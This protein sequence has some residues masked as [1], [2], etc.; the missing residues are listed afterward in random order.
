M[1]N[2]FRSLCAGVIVIGLALASPAG[3]L[4]CRRSGSPPGD[5]PEGPSSRVLWVWPPSDLEPGQSNRYSSYGLI[6]YFR[7]T[8]VPA[9]GSLEIT[10]EPVCQNR[11]VYSG[12]IVA[13]ILE[14]DMPSPSRKVTVTDA[15][16]GSKL[17]E[18]S[19]PA[20]TPLPAAS[21]L[22]V[23][24]SEGRTM[25]YP[26]GGYYS[27]AGPTS[28]PLGDGGTAYVAF[29]EVMA[30]VWL[31]GSV[32]EQSLRAALSPAPPATVTGYRPD[33]EGGTLIQVRWPELPAVEGSPFPDPAA[34]VASGKAPA[35]YALEMTLT[36][37]AAKLPASSGAAVA[38]G[39]D[40]RFEVRAVRKPAPDFAV[41]CREPLRGSLG[42]ANPVGNTIFPYPGYRN[43]WWLTPEP[44]TFCIRFTKPMDR[45]S[46]ERALIAESISTAATTVTFNWLTDRAVDVVLAPRLGADGEPT[47][48]LMTRLAAE[49]AVDT[50]GLPIWFVDSLWL[51]WS[52]PMELALVPAAGPD[53]ARTPVLAARHVPT[54]A[55]I[56]DVYDVPGGMEGEDR[57]AS[58]GAEGVSAGCFY[59]AL[60]PAREPED[61]LAP[62]VVWIGESGIT[63]QWWDSSSV[64]ES[65]RSAE[66]L[67]NR[68]VFIDRYSSWEVTD[69]SKTRESGE[70]LKVSLDSETYRWLGLW[71][72]PDGQRVAAFRSRRDAP[73]QSEG[74]LAVDLVIYDLEGR[75]TLVVPDATRL[76]NPYDFYL[77][78]IPTAWL[79]DGSGL[80]FVDRI[81]STVAGAPDGW[82]GTTR[83]ARLDL[84]AGSQAR[85]T[86]LPNSGGASRG[87]GGRLRVFEAGTGRQGVAGDGALYAAGFV[88]APDGG[89]DEFRVESL[90][91]GE[92]L[93][94]AR[95]GEK[96]LPESVEACLPS[97]D[98]RFLAVSG[99]GRTVVLDVAALVAAGGQGTAASTPP[100]VS[101]YDGTVV[102]WTDD[103]Q[104]VY[105]WR[106]GE[107][108]WGE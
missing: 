15:A 87:Q 58:G 2:F 46:V 85:P 22:R 47:T 40:G 24:I 16:S 38:A 77:D 13:V 53:G 86:P 83:L 36:I 62:S 79:P 28:P 76:E 92:V 44:H 37:D 59:L 11:V 73:D 17:A 88:H 31:P 54:G 4:G 34:A 94:A 106:P 52:E 68:Q 21:G 95:P 5:K 55:R 14:G 45:P 99:S 61:G 57:S 74:S 107:W 7:F 91:T 108:T 20:P 98:G 75:E 27:S 18:A 102:A 42:P 1:T 69:I 23:E 30:S 84:T 63:L 26:G 25:P 96:S 8:D 39:P 100:I 49:G 29:G 82:Y 9:E 3:G 103:S 10:V 67:G 60:E 65:C 12:N 89:P 90:E 56:V 66:F 72:S 19:L 80:V 51:R 6:A 33:W 97:P 78:R 41:D 43:Q 48:P 81:A 101:S 50:D 70:T 93:F 104:G 35:G 71:P 64:L 105:V 32:P